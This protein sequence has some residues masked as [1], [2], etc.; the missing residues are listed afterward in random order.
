VRRD[1]AVDGER[2]LAF[3]MIEEGE[4]CCVF[5]FLVL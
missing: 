3:E 4:F 2:C 1:R 5:D